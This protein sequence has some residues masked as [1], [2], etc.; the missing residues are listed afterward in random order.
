MNKKADGMDIL[1]ICF[2]VLTIAAY[3]TFFYHFFVEQPKVIEHNITKTV[4]VEVIKTIEVIKEI[5][6]PC[7]VISCPEI[8]ECPKN[9]YTRDYVLRIIREAKRCEKD[10]SFFNVSECYY[11][12]NKTEST[13]RDCKGSCCRW[14]STWC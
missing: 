11:E 14:N 6:R 9:E 3:F 12:L 5:D 8:K 13:L 10:E 2:V 7:P 1:A 4:E